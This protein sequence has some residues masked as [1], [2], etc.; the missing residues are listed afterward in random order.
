MTG[1]PPDN[2]VNAAADVFDND[3]N[4]ATFGLGIIISRIHMLYG[5]QYY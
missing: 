1:W 4:L 3:N 5:I 2:Q